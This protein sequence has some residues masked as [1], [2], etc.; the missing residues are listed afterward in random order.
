MSRLT[1]GA[2]VV[3]ILLVGLP[4]PAQEPP[5]GDSPPEQ[6]PAPVDP[7]KKELARKHY[8][9]G[10]QLY[11]TSNYPAALAE[12]EK[13]YQLVPKPA[14]LFNIARTYE[15]LAELEKAVAS[16]ESYLQQAPAAENADLVRARLANLKQRLAQGKEDKQDKQDKPPPAPQPVEPPSRWKRTAGWVTLGVGVASLG[17]GI[18]FGVLAKKK[19]DEYESGADGSKLYY[20]LQDI[21]RDGKRFNNIAIAT[22]VAGGVLAA[23]GAGLVVWDALSNRKPE[24]RS[25]FLLPFVDGSGAGLAASFEL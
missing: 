14:L 25:A 16:Y 24:R 7:A 22:L 1:M 8:E 18:A 17:T 20:E 21:D 4:A 3:G 13:A 11:R 2:V 23:A 9:L 10:E 12:F 19:A 6:E 15:V 5:S